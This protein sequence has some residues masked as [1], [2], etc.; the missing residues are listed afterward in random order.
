MAKPEGFAI[1]VFLFPDNK[2]FFKGRE[3][4]E[5]RKWHDDLSEFFKGREGLEGREGRKW[6]DDLS[7]FF[8]GLEG[9]EGRKWQQSPHGAS[10]YYAP[11][12][13]RVSPV[14]HVPWKFAK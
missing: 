2:F 6:H 12:V 11:C 8:K 10:S 5:G 4:L 9:Q 13:A 1:A 14:P 7:E 3:G